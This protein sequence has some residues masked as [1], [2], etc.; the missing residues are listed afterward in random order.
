MGWETR[1]VF[2][3][4]ARRFGVNLPPNRTQCMRGLPAAMSDLWA[5]NQGDDV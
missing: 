3:Q 4:G 5:P 2:P 1:V